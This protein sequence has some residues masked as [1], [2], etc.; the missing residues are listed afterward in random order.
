[1]ILIIG[2]DG[3]LGSEVAKILPKA[4][5]VD[6]K[7]V[8]ITTSDGY[9]KIIDLAPKVIINCA[10]YTN[11]DQAEDDKDLCKKINVD[12]VLTLA[13]A[14]KSLDA[15]LIHISTDYV[16]DGKKESGYSPE[17]K[18]NPIN[19]Y[20]QTKADG[21]EIIIGNLKEYY[22]IRTAWLFGRNGDNFVKTIIRLCS[23]KDEIRVVD[24]QFGSPTYAKDLAVQIKDFAENQEKYPYGVYHFTNSKTCSWFEFA[25]EIKMQ[26]NLSCRII[27]CTSNEFPTKAKRPRF[28]VLLS[29]LHSRPWREALK[30][31]LEEEDGF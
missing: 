8:D 30:E 21:E 22:I 17:D 23:K 29:T 28:S 20:G 4:K 9:Q 18:K 11:V 6:K 15:T 14:A 10:A 26:R 2:S 3:M 13:R 5:A 27:P 16:F 24:D 7:E 25:E 1:M 19:F 12:G 31:Y